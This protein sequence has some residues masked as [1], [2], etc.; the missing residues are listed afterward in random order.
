MGEMDFTDVI[1]DPDFNDELMLTRSPELISMDGIAN[2]NPDTNT[3]WGI[4]TSK[5]TK[6]LVRTPEGEFIKGSITVH[7]T[8]RLIAGEGN[9][10]A[11]I[12]TWLYR[13]RNTRWTVVNVGDYSQFGEGFV[14]AECDLIPLR[15]TPSVD[16][17]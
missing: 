7:T 1:T 11:D 16:T 3:F 4:I 9:T 6:Q 13:G 12:V 5:G 2:V 14:W 8:V 10:T 15:S 17:I